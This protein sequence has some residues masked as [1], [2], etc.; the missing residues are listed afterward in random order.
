MDGIPDVFFWFWGPWVLVL[1]VGHDRSF[2][3]W[4]ESLVFDVFSLD[5]QGSPKADVLSGPGGKAL[6]DLGF[7]FDLATLTN[8]RASCSTCRSG[9][10]LFVLSW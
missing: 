9:G 3:G 10:S 5:P 4:W 7:D 6:T 8:M 2:G 1:V